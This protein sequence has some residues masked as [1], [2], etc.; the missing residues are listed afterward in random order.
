MQFENEFSEFVKHSE[1]LSARECACAGEALGEALGHGRVGVAYR[2]GELSNACADAVSAG[3]RTAGVDVWNFGVLFEAQLSFLVPFCSLKAGVFISADD[4]TVSVFGENGLSI[5][6]ALSEKATELMRSKIGTFAVCGSAFDMSAMTM[7]YRDELSRILPR[8]VTDCAVLSSNPLITA[9]TDDC[10]R[11]T[12]SERRLTF[13]INRW[14]TS[15]TAYSEKTGVVPFV[16]L[17]AMCGM[18]ELESGS[19]ISVPYDAPAFLDELARSCGR[20]AYRYLS[21]PSDG[22]DNIARRLAARQFWS[23]D[24]LFTAARIMSMM[25]EKCVDFSTLYEKL[26]PFFVYSTVAKLDVPPE[27]LSEFE[28]ENFSFDRDGGNGFVLIE[29]R[30]QAHI[31]PV[32]ADKVRLTVQSVNEETAQELCADIQRI[33]SEKGRISKPARTVDFP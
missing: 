12:G 8:C 4:G 16:K 20:T 24:A 11:I 9:L 14:G 22:S 7:L 18:Y 6:T 17:V 26:P 19:D 33:L 13:R 2:S 31:S 32:S 1:S 25:E 30:G 23:R 21:A 3:L 27:Y 28:G 29:K 5:S 10:M 15:L